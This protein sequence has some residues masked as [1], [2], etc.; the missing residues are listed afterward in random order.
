MYLVVEPTQPLNR[1]NHSMTS[2]NEFIIIYGGYDDW[3]WISYFELWT[4]NTISDIWRRY[5]P[6]SET[7]NGCI[8]SS[9]CAVGNL[10]Y[11]FGGK[12]YRDLRQLSNSLHSF[13]IRKGT[14][15]I[16]SPHI[17]DYGINTPPPLYGSSICHHDGCLYIL[18]GVCN[19]DIFQSVYKFCLMTSTWSLVHQNGL[20]P[21]LGHRVLG[22]VF[23]NQFYTF[24]YSGRDAPNRFKF[25]N[26]FNFSTNTWT[27]EKQTRKTQ[28]YPDSDRIQESFSFSN[29]CGYLSGGKNSTRYYSDIWKIDLET[30]E[31]FKLKYNLNICMFFHCTAVVNDCFLYTYGGDGHYSHYRN[32]L[33]RFTV[34]PPTLYRLCIEYIRRSLNL[35]TCAKI[36]PTSILNDLNLG[37]DS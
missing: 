34:Q 30:L 18:G 20:L 17:D 21:L 29:T 13:N 24:G 1:T 28:L 2:A 27:P 9:I 3:S 36:L 11:I 6:P 23:K 22:T 7:L 14:W 33:E 31:W 8:L 37:S 5:K 19:D 12:H 35:M 4:Y 26:I 25:I 16:L 15:K 10:V 32:S